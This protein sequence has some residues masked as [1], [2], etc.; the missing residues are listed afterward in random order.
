MSVEVRVPTV[1]RRHTGGERKVQANGTT[2]AAVLESLVHQFPGL[3]D[4]LLNED[5]QVR[6]FV[7]I[8][9]N[10]EDIRYLDRLETAVGDGDNLAILPAVAGG[11]ISF[12]SLSQGVRGSSV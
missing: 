9:V 1:L 10:D 11:T 6:Q 7:N 12:P 8:Y 3:K 4:E 5:G 2:V